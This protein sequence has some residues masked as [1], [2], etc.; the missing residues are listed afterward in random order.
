MMTNEEKLIRTAL[1]GILYEV[2]LI[3]RNLNTELASIIH[4]LA[5]HAHNIPLWLKQD[6]LNP[7]EIQHY[8]ESERVYCIEKLTEIGFADELKRFEPHWELVQSYLY[9]KL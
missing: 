4:V 5:D 7:A 2:L 9:P 8:Y 3:A 1:L 6:Q